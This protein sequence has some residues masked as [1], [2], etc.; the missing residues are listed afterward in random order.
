MLMRK[1]RER[2]ITESLV[3]SLFGLA[4]SKFRED[5]NLIVP[6]GFRK[7]LYKTIEI[8]ILQIKAYFKE[9]QKVKLTMDFISIQ[10]DSKRSYTLE[11]LN[12]TFRFS[13]AKKAIHK[14][15]SS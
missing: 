8:T 11:K 7:N 9:I 2:R 6:N 1:E 12:L 13:M 10:K 5:K 15:S 14:K 3:H 4:C